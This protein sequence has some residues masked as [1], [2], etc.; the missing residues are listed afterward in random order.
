[1]TSLKLTIFSTQKSGGPA[2]A[3]LSPFDFPR[4]VGV[5]NLFLGNDYF[6][7]AGDEYCSDCAANGR[8]LRQLSTA[9]TSAG[10]SC[11][12]CLTDKSETNA[13]SASDASIKLY[14]DA[15]QDS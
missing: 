10:L 8:G 4:A 14:C 12:W 1:M 13:D 11:D 9:G 2:A 3:S 7:H 5:L 6:T 15:P